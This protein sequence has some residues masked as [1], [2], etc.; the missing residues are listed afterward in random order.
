[1]K[2]PASINTTRASFHAFFLVPFS[3]LNSNVSARSAKGR[4]K[5]KVYTG[6][7]RRRSED[8]SQ[9]G[10]SDNTIECTH[11]AFYRNQRRELGV[12]TRHLHTASTWVNRGMA[13]REPAAGLCSRHPV[14]LVAPSR[15]GHRE[16][17]GV[18]QRETKSHQL[19]CSTELHREIAGEPLCG[20]QRPPHN[21]TSE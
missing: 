4:I 16:K 5:V 1:M 19:N 3:D 8:R 2:T 10:A 20:T 15:A 14:S 7:Q 17:R 9:K 6:K 12:L 21:T 11:N 18:T 13:E